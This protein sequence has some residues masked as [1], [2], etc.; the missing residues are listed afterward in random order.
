MATKDAL[1]QARDE[2][3]RLYH[4]HSM[5][6]QRGDVHVGVA[7]WERRNGHC[8]YNT[9][10]EERRFNKRVTGAI[11]CDGEHTVLINSK[12][13]EDS[14]V[15]SFN[16]TVRHEVAHV[17]SWEADEYSGHGEPWKRWARKLGADPSA[18][19]SKKNR[20]Y[21]YYLGCPE[22]CFTNGYHRR[23]K[24]I[25]N[26]HTRVCAQC[27]ATCVSYEA[28]DRRPTKPGTCAVSLD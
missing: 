1:Q 16:D 17:C 27:G 18:C 2:V 25:Q 5:P 7:R 12:I 24:R 13:L 22:G 8:R 11:E 9:A 20:E 26:P 19:H 10:L 23:S 21:S 15:A 3:T 4:N 6:M 28:G 14:G